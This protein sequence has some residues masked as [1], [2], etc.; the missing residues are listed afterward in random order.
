[1]VHGLRERGTPGEAFKPRTGEGHVAYVKGDYERAEAQGVEMTELL[2]ETYGGVAPSF[3]QLMREAATARAN[4]LTS[5]EY[6]QTTWSA[7]T[8][9]TFSMQRISVAL[10]RAAAKEISD[11]LGLSVVADTRGGW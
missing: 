3:L 5:G 2:I 10:H 1:M 4:K 7:R 11:A 9:T 8:F 6:D